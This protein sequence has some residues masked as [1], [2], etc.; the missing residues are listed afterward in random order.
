MAVATHTVAKRKR[1]TVAKALAD[2]KIGT[3]RWFGWRDPYV[4]PASILADFLRSQESFLT[5][6]ISEE[7]STTRSEL[8]WLTVLSCRTA[9]IMRCREEAVIRR[10]YDIL[11][12]KSLATNTDMG[13]AFVM[14]CEKN[15]DQDTNIPVLPSNRYGA[16]DLLCVRAEETGDRISKYDLIDMIPGLLSLSA[17]IIESP[18]LLEHLRDDAPFNCLRPLER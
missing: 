12:G 15:L 3:P 11:H 17:A 10:L 5:A 6:H 14:A 8:G 2:I 16:F 9:S 1:K 7:V 18:E 4:L 13:E